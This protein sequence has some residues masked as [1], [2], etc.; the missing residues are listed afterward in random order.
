MRKLGKNYLL[1]L[2]NTLRWTNVYRLYIKLN[3]RPDQRL[4]LEGYST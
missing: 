1:E 2:G 3:S 4:L